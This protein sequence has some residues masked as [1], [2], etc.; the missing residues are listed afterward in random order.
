[1]EAEK[2]IGSGST[3][4]FHDIYLAAFRSVTECKWLQVR[5][6]CY[7][8]RICPYGYMKEVK[9][10]HNVCGFKMSTQNVQLVIGKEGDWV[11]SVEW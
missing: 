9:D 2:E 3:S 5:S 4:I 7:E 8:K 10:M 1:M 11:V 6:M